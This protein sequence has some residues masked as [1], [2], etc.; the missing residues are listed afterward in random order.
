[1]CD[2]D[3]RLSDVVLLSVESQHTARI[4]LNNFASKQKITVALSL[5]LL[6]F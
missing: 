3:Q 5:E 1:M 6:R 2:G 4:D